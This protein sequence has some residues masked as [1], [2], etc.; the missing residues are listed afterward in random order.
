MKYLPLAALIAIALL[1]ACADTTPP[2]LSTSPGPD[3]PAGPSA[4][5]PYR[6][7]MAGTADHGVGSRP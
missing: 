7:V 1:A 4:G 2:P 3:D 5:L 6:P